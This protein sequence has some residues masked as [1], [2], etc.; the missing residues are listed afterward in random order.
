MCSISKGT[1]GDRAR[2]RVSG[3]ED[4]L[5]WVGWETTCGGEQEANLEQVMGASLGAC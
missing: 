4:E 5:L 3:R 2:R 1:A